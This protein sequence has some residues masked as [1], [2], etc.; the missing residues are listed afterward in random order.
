VYG[1]REAHA[2]LQAARASLDALRLS[3]RSQLLA[4]LYQLRNAARSVQA[5]G[6]LA[7]Q[8][9]RQ[10]E[11]ARGRYQAGVGNAI[12]LGDAAVTAASAQAQRVQAD[13]A[14]FG[15][16]ATLL[17]HLGQLIPTQQPLAAAS[18]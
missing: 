4:A 11:M 7:T 1:L 12:E 6:A 14:L 16:R 9:G 5:A 18:P 17:W 13:Y 15:A 3:M 2:N 8:A 10:L